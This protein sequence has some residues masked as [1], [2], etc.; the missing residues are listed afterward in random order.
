MQSCQIYAITNS[1]KNADLLVEHYD[2]S[3]DR[4]CCEKGLL[5][6]SDVRSQIGVRGVD[7]I[8]NMVSG[9]DIKESWGL[10]ADGGIMIDLS[11]AKI[12]GGGSLPMEPFTRNCSFRV[13]DMTS[14]KISDVLIHK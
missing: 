2:L 11:M 9:E 10:C 7:V 5:W 6:T 13:V 4:V 1:Q 14:E 12:Q 8:V 3:R